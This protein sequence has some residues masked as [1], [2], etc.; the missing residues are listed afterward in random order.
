MKL[1]EW[2]IIGY[3]ILILVNLIAI[4]YDIVDIRHQ[5]N[6]IERNTYQQPT[7]NITW[8]DTGVK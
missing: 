8:Y 4:R 1:F 2:L 7:D 3:C 6:L 5:I